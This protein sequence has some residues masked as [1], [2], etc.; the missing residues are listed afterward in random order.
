VTHYATDNELYPIAQ[1]ALQRSIA[2]MANPNPNTNATSA[3]R[4]R[5]ADKM[6]TATARL[7]PRNR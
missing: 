7:N 4:A 1:E 2:D 6:A 3:D 5:A